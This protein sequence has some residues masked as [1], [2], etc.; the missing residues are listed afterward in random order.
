M[1]GFEV[2]LGGKTFTINEGDSVKDLINKPELK[3]LAPLF[4][5][6]DNSG[7]AMGGDGILDA[8]EIDLLQ[9]ALSGAKGDIKNYDVDKLCD[10]YFNS[11]KNAQEYFKDNKIEKK[12]KKEKT[13][14][15]SSKAFNQFVQTLSQRYD[16]EAITT[17]LSGNVKKVKAGETL[18]LIAKSA[19]E[20]EG[21][22]PTSKEINE[23]MAQ[24]ALVNNIHDVN[25]IR[26]GTKLK[27]GSARTSGSAASSASD[28][29]TPTAADS[30]TPTAVDNTAPTA[31]DNATPSSEVRTAPLEAGEKGELAKAIAD[32]T[33]SITVSANGLNMGSGMPVDKDGNELKDAK[34]KRN[35]KDPKFKAGG[36]IMKYTSGDTVMYQTTKKKAEGKLSSEVKL[37]ASSIEE[38]KE[39]EKKF[40]ETIAKVKPPVE[41]ETEEAAKA[42]KAENLAALKELVTLTGGNIQVIKNVAEKL[43]EDDYVDRTSDE[44][45]GFVQDLL[46]TRNADVINAMFEVKGT[47]VNSVAV[48]EKD[49]TAH[50]ILAGMYQEIRAKEKAGEKLSDEEIE[51]KSS[52]TALKGVSGYKVEAD[53]QNGVHEKYMSYDNMD[54][55]P[56]YQVEIDDNWYYA[57]DPKLLDEFLTKL[58]S[59]DTDEKKSALFKEY[60][61]TQDSDLAKCLAQNVKALKAKDEDIISLVHANGMEVLATLPTPDGDDTTYSDEVFDA[62]ISRAKE[63]VTTD[64]GNLENAVRLYNISDWI[65]NSGKTDEEKDKIRTEILET[66]FEVTQNEEGNKTYTFNPSRRPTYEEMYGLAGLVCDA[67]DSLQEALAKYTKLEDM[68]KGQYN[69]AIEEKYYGTYT[70][71]HYAE[72]VEKMSTPEEVIDFIDNKVAAY[73]NCHLPFDKIIEKFPDDKEIADRLVTNIDINSTISDESKL[74]L[75]KH[76]MKTEGDKV[77]FDKSKLPKEASVRNVIHY[78]LPK[79]CKKGDTAK[80]FEAILKTL[81]KD[82][83]ETISE[84]KDKNPNLAKS[85]ISE[86]VNENKTDN[87]F[88]QK[89]MKLDRSIIPF[90]TLTK[91]DAAEAKWNNDTKALV[92]ENMFNNRI[93]VKDLTKRLENAVNNHLIVK[94][95]EDGYAIGD[96]IYKTNWYYLGADKKYGTE[97]DTVSLKKISK[98]GYEHGVAMF[99]ELEGAGSGD[100][101]KML[102]GKKEE[103]FENYVTPDN[104]VGIIDGFYSKSPNEGLMEYIANE[105][106]WSGGTKPGKALCNRIPKA[107]MKKAAELGLQDKKEYKELANFFGCSKDGK[108]TF[109]KN[110]EADQRYDSETAAQLDELI[111]N[112]CKEVMM[113]S[114]V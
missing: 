55:T 3:T 58:E 35:F 33:S 101:A 38:L 16:K 23:R 84:N 73:K 9:K 74:K 15:A 95:A 24:I 105:W 85:R 51:L 45:K 28:R 87:E 83:I 78:I 113:S 69:D 80:Y 103:G 109:T 100:I 21:K 64:K 61:N 108:F 39:L 29:T 36:N 34:G 68:G 96:T 89:V 13:K 97:D 70:V 86:L 72:M 81:G 37:S 71:P 106:G 12:E 49:K 47:D 30:T 6:V 91:I 2:N 20:A 14:Q 52:L 94:V 18:Y 65:N 43:R 25:N 82:D 90:E 22:T 66:Y 44:Y 26:V 77:T 112:L 17:Q 59:A 62:V 41:N 53:T 111:R 110:D 114:G 67:S 48:I 56:L 8:S 31:A 19:L 107:L 32:K 63:I 50:E 4:D 46:L 42:R 93:L 54:G 57:K 40:D 75:I 10:E 7:S 60:V 11:G 5:L 99:E 76:Y 27:I 102:R 104:V 88:I 79:D 92:F 98:T 1:A